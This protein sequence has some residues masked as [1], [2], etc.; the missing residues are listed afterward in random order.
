MVVDNTLYASI[1][2][3]NFRAGTA[4]PVTELVIFDM[5]TG[6]YEVL[7][8]NECPLGRPTVAG[9]HVYVGRPAGEVIAV[10]ADKAVIRLYD[11][12]FGPFGWGAAW[13]GMRTPAASYVCFV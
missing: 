9:D 2:H 13:L 4:A 1:Y 11:A 3:R 12:D 10:S 6:G 5:D 8:D 7:V